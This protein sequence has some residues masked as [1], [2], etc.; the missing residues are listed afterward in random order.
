[1]LKPAAIIFDLD[2]V[3][4]NTVEFHFAGWSAV[5]RELGVAFS[6]EDNDKL[7]GVPRREALRWLSREI[8]EFSREREEHLLRLKAEVYRR[9][10]IKAGNLIKIPG[11]ECL[12][13]QLREENVLIG[14]ASASRHAPMLL[15]ITG[16]L[17]FFD[18]VSDGNFKGRP[19][20]SPEQL[21]YL[22]KQLKVQPH[23]C[24]VVEDSVAGL[25][26]AWQAGMHSVAI[27]GLFM[28]TASAS[29]VLPSLANM[30]L[31]E[32]L[33]AVERSQYLYSE[34]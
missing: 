18:A 10:I 19:K 31:H 20:P 30:T 4:I 16:L 24:V 27:G 11:I 34:R 25:E 21:L 29:V 13:A 28:K 17:K 12:L 2:G 9:E 32:F 5:A 8:N 33:S 1:M 15:E 22:A 26:A 14:L 23:E 3:L 7:R 6:R